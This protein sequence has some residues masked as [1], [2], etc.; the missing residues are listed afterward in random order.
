VV[1]AEY[2]GKAVVLLNGLLQEQSTVPAYK[3]LL[4][5]CYREKSTLSVPF[6]EINWHDRKEAIGLL[7]QLVKHYPKVPEYRFDLSETLA[8]LDV[9]GPFGPYS[10][11]KT[12]EKDAQ[13]ALRLS[14]DL[15]AEHPNV[16][17]YQ[18]SKAQIH[19]RLG[20]IQRFTQR[21]K[22]E[23]NLRQAVDLQHA[24]V[25]RFPRVPF[26]RFLKVVFQ[27]ALVDV[28][29]DQKKWEESRPLLESSLALLKQ[30]AAEDQHVPFLSYTLAEDYAKLAR[31][32]YA[33]GS[34]RLGL[35]ADRQYRELRLAM[36]KGPGFGKDRDKKQPPGK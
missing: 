21:D 35:Q 18:L 17:D 19:F 30:L 14:R 36:P 29:M 7:E 34:R 26:H 1:R 2:L 33:L 11:G 6:S 9:R 5:L 8:L 4:A 23:K 25:Q 32:H 10:G 22:A 28:L 16:P 13:E 31:V 12:P 15:V 3:H 24:L 27:D 20:L